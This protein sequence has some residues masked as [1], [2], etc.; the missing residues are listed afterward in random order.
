MSS[1]SSILCLTIA[2]LF[3]I[4][5][6]IEFAVIQMTR[7]RRGRDMKFESCQPWL[8]KLSV[9]QGKELGKGTGNKGTIIS[10]WEDFNAV[11]I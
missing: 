8:F 7:E 4:V 10:G 9:Q 6:Y 5:R 2:V 3:C 11:H 1:W